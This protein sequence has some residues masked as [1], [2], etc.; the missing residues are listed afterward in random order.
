MTE[1]EVLLRRKSSH[2]E[3]GEEGE[4]LVG[5]GQREERKRCRIFRLIPCERIDHT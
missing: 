3:R 1:E 4:G 2:G 5:G